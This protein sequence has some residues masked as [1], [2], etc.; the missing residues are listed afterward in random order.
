MHKIKAYFENEIKIQW[1]DF[2]PYPPAAT[3][4]E[5]EEQDWQV[6]MMS[7]RNQSLRYILI[8]KPDFFGD[9]KLSSYMKEK[10]L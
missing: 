3:E 9:V 8:D 5:M 6:F 1:S 4:E 2:E 7:L 10:L